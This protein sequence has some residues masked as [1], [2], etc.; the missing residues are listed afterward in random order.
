MVT[1]FSTIHHVQTR[2]LHLTQRRKESWCR[3][4]FIHRHAGVSSYQAQCNCVH[5]W[6]AV[7]HVLRPETSCI[8]LNTVM[9]LS[10]TALTDIHQFKSLL[11]Y[12]SF[13]LP[14]KRKS[15][16]GWIQVIPSYHLLDPLSPEH[17]F[18]L[19]LCWNIYMMK[20]RQGTIFS[21]LN[22]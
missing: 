8:H 11:L 2:F 6:R 22:F 16:V 7:S 9:S 20:C 21:S 10:F 14:T 13:H 17:K 4:K 15:E 18:S 12:H 1:V 19:K 5:S 3:I